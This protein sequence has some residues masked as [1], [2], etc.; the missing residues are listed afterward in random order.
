MVAQHIE[1]DV[2]VVGAGSAGAAAAGML[3]GT[4]RA[5]A[6]LESR[7]FARAGARWQN[8]VPAWMF[9]RAGLPPPAGAELVRPGEP[10][11]M[12]GPFGQARTALP[13]SILQVDV[14]RLNDRLLAEARRAGARCV[15]GA[16]L[17]EVDLGPDGRPR[18]A[19]FALAPW[20][21][22]RLEVR[23][24]LFL[25]ATGRAGALR[26]RLPA[27]AAAAPPRP[28]EVCLAA[29]EVRAVTDAVAARAFLERLGLE[30]GVEAS[31]LGLAGGFSVSTVRV[32]P[33]LGSVA[34]LAGTDGREAGGRVL[35]ERLRAA[36]PWIGPR[37]R[38]GEGAIDLRR[39]CA[40][41]AVPGAALLGEAGRLVFPLHAS[42]TGAGL[43]SAR[44]L[45]EALDSSPD[46]GAAEV[47]WRYQATVQCSLGGVHAAYD[48]LRR[49]I[50][51]LAPPEVE[52]LI[53]SG[54]LTPGLV[55]AGLE[56][57]LPGP[58]ALEPWRQV[59]GLPRLLGSPELARALATRL[60]RMALALA[61]HRAY[62]ER[63]DEAALGRWARAEARLL[64][65]D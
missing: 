62:P 61:V 53:A 46:P 45:A 25:D 33:D 10:W 43:V 2:A 50:A 11:V 52:R 3:A 19:G 15:E 65:W 44:L 23:A 26:T 34:L 8:G 27:W 18:T 38:G 29:Q 1:V 22:G 16:E 28:E 30:P 17:V 14:G 57:R 21:G 32:A 36:E 9:E 4:G 49:L 58:G 40:N 39:P 47:A 12:L 6:L 51:A 24:R 37:L 48:V 35:L 55:T 41:L 31:R 60:P 5:V 63:P 59:R 54:L 13:T 7:P 56:Q 20:P 42:G 64:D